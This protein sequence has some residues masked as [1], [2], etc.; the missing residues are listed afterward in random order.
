M[1]EK[2]QTG[3]TSAFEILFRRYEK[4]VYRTAYLI[5][6]SKEA[7][8]DVL[9]EVFVSV[10]RSRHTYDSAKGKLTTWLHRITVNQCSRRKAGKASVAISLEEKGIGRPSTYVPIIRTIIFRDYVRRKKSYF[11]PTE[12]GIT[13]ND[14]LTKYFPRILDVK[15]TAT[16]EEEL[17]AIEEGKLDWVKVLKI[18]YEPFIQELSIAQKK[19]KKEAIPTDEIC[20]L[21]ARPMVIKW[22]R[23]G[24][25]LSCSGFPKCKN[26]RSI[27]TEVRCAQQGCNGWLVERRTKRGSS[28]FGCSNY[29]QCKYATD[30]LPQTE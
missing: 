23:H 18:F 20:E 3:D 17:D 11:F 1:T 14:I 5:T 6:G 7:A 24:R 22:G 25:F 29:P 12:L 8:E 27:T 2:W 28:F 4:L 26:A 16:L 21:C 13:V 30:K 9:Q 15:F 10:W 19:I